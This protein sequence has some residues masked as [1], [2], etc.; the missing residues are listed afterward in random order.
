MRDNLSISDA[1][2]KKKYF[3]VEAYVRIRLVKQAPKYLTTGL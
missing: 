3:F 2:M 1:F